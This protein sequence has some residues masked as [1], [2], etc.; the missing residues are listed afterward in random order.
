MADELA[1]ERGQELKLRVLENF[2]TILR[3][4]GEDRATGHRWHLLD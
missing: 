3:E 2:H 1:G 4:R